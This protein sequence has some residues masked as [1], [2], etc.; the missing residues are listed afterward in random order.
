M[1]ANATFTGP[2]TGSCPA[3]QWAVLPPDCP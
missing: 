2:A 3:S 1:T